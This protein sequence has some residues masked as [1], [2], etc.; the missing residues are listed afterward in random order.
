MN[1]SGASPRM[2]LVSFKPMVKNALGG[3]AT[4]ELPN[5][6]KIIDC[7]VLTIDGKSWVAFPA[8][9]QL[10]RDGKQIVINGEKQFAAILSW[11]DRETSDRWS[12]AVVDLVKGG[13]P[14]GA[15][16][17]ATAQS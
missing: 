5:G 15:V 14:P 4:I 8:K 7:P 17:T 9:P 11:P 16:I 3:F 12:D 2:R 6:L 10:D 13:A 1:G